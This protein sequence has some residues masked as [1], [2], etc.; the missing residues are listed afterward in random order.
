MGIMGHRKRNNIYI[1]RIPEGKKKG[2]ESIFKDI[3]AEN[4]LN[5]GRE[6]DIQIH[7]DQRTPNSLNS[8]RATMRHIIIKLSKAKDKERILRAAREKREVTCKGL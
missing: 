1:V 4:F 5:L 6:M 2:T 7:R 3:M 8:N